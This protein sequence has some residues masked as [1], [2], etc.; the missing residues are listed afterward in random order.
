MT[1]PSPPLP[2][3]I[4]ELA[5][6]TGISVRALRHYDEIGL[7]EPSARTAAGYRLYDAADVA[8]L[9]QIV[10]LRQ[11]G[12]SLAEA[13][14]SLRR[15]DR[16][17]LEVIEIQIERLRQQIERQ[18]DLHRRLQGIAAR[19]RAAEDV[20]AADLTQII[21]RMQMFDK[22]FTPEQR[23]ELA[24]RARQLG[25]DRMREAEAEWPRLI[26]RMRAAMEGGADPAS[27][28]VRQLARRW[29]ALIEDFTGGN[30]GIATSVRNL[31]DQ[32]P[33][34]SRQQGLDREL[35][36][37]VHRALAAIGAIGAI[38]AIDRVTRPPG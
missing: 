35:F 25:P 21:W 32:E 38:G 29:Q 14:A 12:L 7:L 22:Y 34:L 28:P 16:S 37:Y 18:Q 2:W 10:S 31:Y 17:P 26:S 23:E 27:E 33:G 36:E 4:G 1:M 30:P 15:A 9:Q 19:L 24:E 3:K 6:H 13:G 8:R 5:R 20:S 11:L